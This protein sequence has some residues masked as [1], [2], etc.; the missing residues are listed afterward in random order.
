ML[1]SQSL[2]LRGGQKTEIR[3]EPYG[4]EDVTGAVDT[5]ER[6]QD[7]RVGLPEGRRPG[8]AAVGTVVS[9]LTLQT[10]GQLQER[11]PAPLTHPGLTAEPRMCPLCSFWSSFGSDYGEW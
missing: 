9:V 1:T 5:Y 7:P 10:Q 4:M 11:P 2:I 8:Q 3:S 6:D